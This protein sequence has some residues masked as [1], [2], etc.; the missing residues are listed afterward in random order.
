[1]QSRVIGALVEA[2]KAA[3]GRLRDERQMRD[4]TEMLDDGPEVLLRGHPADAI[5][6]RER[7]RP[8]V[9]AERPLPIPVVVVLEVREHELADRA[10]DGRPV[11]QPSEL[12][13]RDGAPETTVPVHRKDV[14]VV[15][16]GLEVH[17]E[18]RPAV[19]PERRR[20]EERALRAVRGAVTHHAARRPHGVAVGLEVVREPV[21]VCLHLLRRVETSQRRELGA[22]QTVHPRHDD[23]VRLAK[24]LALVRTGSS[25]V[26]GRAP[27][28]STCAITTAS[29]AVR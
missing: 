20:R 19:H 12:G 24:G 18:R 8:R 2:G 9:G 23:G 7:R 3:R 5:E 11:A 25:A 10:V 21:E 26:P 16:H 14:V 15:A 27:M 22:R 6:A 17:E 29:G 1:M 13:G 28:R 4:D